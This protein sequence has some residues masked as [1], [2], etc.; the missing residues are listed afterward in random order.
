MVFAGE[1]A[2]VVGVGMF[3]VLP[4]LAAINR[5]LVL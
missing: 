1:D 4:V 3:A 2:I 5:I